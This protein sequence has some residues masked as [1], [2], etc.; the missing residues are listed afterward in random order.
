ML[1]RDCI[2]RRR[3]LAESGSGNPRDDAA[4]IVRGF[5]A[6]ASDADRATL[7]ARQE[8]LRIADTNSRVA[9]S[10]LTQH[11]RWLAVVEGVSAAA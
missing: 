11:S 8:N 1:F 10:H 2:D 4:A 6:T 5:K 7:K 3:E 9:T